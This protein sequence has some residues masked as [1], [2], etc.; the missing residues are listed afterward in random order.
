MS[1]MG[2]W[3]LHVVA[4]GLF[5]TG[6]FATGLGAQERLHV[7][8]PVPQ[9][10]RLGDVARVV[11]RIEGRTADPREPKL[12]VVDG[13]ELTLGAPSRSS[14]TFYDGRTLTERV[15]VQYPLQ[16]RPLRAG[17]FVVPPFPVWTGT[18]EQRT[19]ELRLDVK[20]DLIGAEMGWLDVQ[21]TPQRVYV[22][23]PVRIRVDYGVHQGLRLVQEIY[24]RYRYYDVEVQ[25]GWLGE[26]PGGERIA[27]PEPAGNVQIAVLNR[28][29][30]QVA[31]D[32]DHEKNGQ[33][34]NRFTFERAFLPTRLGR[35]E[36]PAPMLRFHVLRREGQ[37][38]VFGRTRG[39]Q[40]ENYYV[41]GQP[42]VLEVLPIP[43][44]GRPQPYFGAVGRFT[45]QAS[46]DRT[47]VKVGGSLKLTLTVR[48][49]GNLE[50]L[51]LP[52][53]DGLEGFHKLGEAEARR[54][55]EKVVVTYDLTPL[56][57][58][59]RQVPPIAWNWFDTTPGVERFV[60]VATPPL[61]ITVEPL[62]EGERLLP[63]PEVTRAV[64]PG[65]DDIHDLPPFDG[66][67]FVGVPARI[68]DVP[69]WLRW[70]AVAGPWVV[71][72]LLAVGLRRWRRAAADVVGRRARGARR[73]CE[74]ALARGEAPL[75]AFAGYLAARLGVPPAAV[76][77]PDL[78]ERLA[79]AGLSADVAAA[80]AAAIDRGTAARYGGAAAL[81]VG[82]VEALVARIEPHGFLRGAPTLVLAGLFGALSAGG[83][84]RA[85]EPV[86]LDATAAIAA[87]RSGDYA[88]AD[89]AFAA[90]HAATGDRRW[91][92]ARGNAL[93]RLGD[94]PRARWA[95][96]GAQ[97]A[98]PRDD[99]L[100]ANLRLVV[101]RLEIP[102]EAGGLGAAVR[103]FVTSWTPVEQV[104]FAAVSMLLGAG[105]LVFG[106][107]RIGRRWIG[108]FLLAPGV[109]FAVELLW[110]AP[111]RPAVA[112]ALERVA[113][114][115]EPR[116]GLDAIATVRAGVVLDV[117]GSGQ[118]TWLRVRIG[119]QRGYVPGAALAVVP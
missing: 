117:L 92:Q 110:L 74:Q 7:E 8:G 108:A 3:P 107:R 76:I 5:A 72:A 30:V 96:L 9:T 15:G 60:E 25:A 10:L 42:I 101:D 4:V 86:P 24:N 67:G 23:E 87:Y 47:N 35:I 18:Q 11:L 65:V 41:Y 63:L 77:A 93:F 115:A 91:L 103:A 12:P 104:L 99:E 46:L 64:T 36:L 28:Q 2:H 97:K 62:G 26:F 119:D 80:A 54:D 21:V 49:Q 85:Q 89:A 118:G 52:T 17:E 37:Q 20:V 81:T 98:L 50:F 57:E 106:W 34:W 82:E 27:L 109:L 56:H 1:V 90:L 71:V 31:H 44:Q 116:D 38:D 48:G 105:C 6:L 83:A 19:P 33:R 43:E 95:W 113:I 88:R 29:L 102:R 66:G 51:R 45:I 39:Q 94:L 32:P 75:D 78:A 79:A 53:L 100:A 70:S 114:V 14:Q 112:V 13:L 111:S 16:L 22:H 84:L 68:D 59:V 73:P 61:A 40:S 69:P 58:D 55:A